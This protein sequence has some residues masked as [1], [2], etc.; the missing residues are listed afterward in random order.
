MA[1]RKSLIIAAL[2]GLVPAILTLAVEHIDPSSNPIVNGIQGAGMVLLFPGI[3]GSI[4]VSGNAH[5]FHLWVA[6]VC[7]FVLY[8]LLCW[9][10]AAFIGGLRRRIGA[11]RHP[12]NP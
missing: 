10:I 3:L 9:A 1:N 8:F 2:L 11:S 6:A 4:A 7:N 12:D 5:A